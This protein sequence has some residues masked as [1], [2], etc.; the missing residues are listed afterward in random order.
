MAIA[1]DCGEGGR[2]DFHRICSFSPKYQSSHADRLYTN[3]LKNGHG[4]V[5]LGTAFHL[6]QTAGVDIR[7]EK[8]AKDTKMHSMQRMQ[9]RRFL[10]HTHTYLIMRTETDNRTQPTLRIAGKRNFQEAN[11]CS[12]FHCC[13]KPNG[14][15]PCNTSAATAPQ[16]HSAT[17]SCSERSPS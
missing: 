1:T 12:L 11:R 5:H 4:N 15:S 16:E 6:A 2:A 7:E 14:R 13:P 3:A 8:R 17:C 10:T 9:Y